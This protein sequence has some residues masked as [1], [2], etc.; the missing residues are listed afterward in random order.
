MPQDREDGFRE[1]VLMAVTLAGEKQA[2]DVVLL[3]VGKVS[4]LADYF[5]ICTGRSTLQVQVIADHI[6]EGMKKAGFSL[7]RI[8]GYREARWVLLDYGFLV[9][10]IFTPEERLFYNLERLWSSAPALAIEQ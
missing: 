10:H 9:V 3:E 7:A 8:E 4:Y 5:L 1:K 2:R 6:R